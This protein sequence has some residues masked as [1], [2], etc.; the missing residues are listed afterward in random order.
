MA[1]SGLWRLAVQTWSA[2][3]VA[4]LF[5]YRPDLGAP[6]F[7]ARDHAFYWPWKLF[8]WPSRFAGREEVGRRV[9]QAYLACIGLPL[10]G[11]MLNKAGRQGLKGRDDLHG[12]ARWATFKDIEAMGYLKGEGV[13]V[14]G[15]WEP[16]KRVHYYLRHN[17]P[18]RVLCFAPTRG[19]KGVGLIPPTLLS[20]PRSSLVIDING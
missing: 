3:R 14:G 19:G 9:A 5:D 20:W 6:L 13:Y 7:Q 1:L 15:F 17:G 18:E 8:D 4:G 12:S 2:D 16:K 11:F 10:L